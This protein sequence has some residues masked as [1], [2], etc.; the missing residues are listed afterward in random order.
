LSEAWYWVSIERDV[1]TITGSDAKSY[2]HS[3]LSQDIASMQPGEVRSSL[4]LQPTGK[5]DSL[6][7]VTCAAADRFVLDCDPGFGESTVARLS[8]FKIRVNADIELQRQT[9]RAIRTTSSVADL[10]KISQ[11]FDVSGAIPAWRSDGTAFDIFS[12]TMA[13]PATLREGTQDEFVASRVRAL[14]PEMG[15]DITT[16][17]IPAETGV[18]DVAVSFT[19]G[20][21][22]GQE[23]VERMDSRGS[24]AP[25]R[26][27]RV[28]CAPGAKVGNDV[29]INDEIVGVFTT[30]AG[31]IALALIKR[32]VELGDPIG[33]NPTL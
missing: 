17:M 2:L 9:W 12:P 6:L 24:M 22:P 13:L 28:I 33:E 4:L 10:E 29:V 18:V 23:L 25:R 14:W 1:I 31:D 5:V 27:C 19:K 20:C 7:R 15:T 21:Y 3:Q 8:R 26:L 32:G 30:V 11:P 16:D